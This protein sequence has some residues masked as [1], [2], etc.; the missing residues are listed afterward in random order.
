MA[1]G[2]CRPGAGRPKTGEVS[3]EDEVRKETRG[4]NLTPL[5]YMLSVMNDDEAEPV[6]RDRMAMAA[7]P[8]VHGRATDIEPGKKEQR[9]AKAEKSASAG[10]FASPVAPKL[11][12]NNR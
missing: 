3:V 2:G 4:T 6:R 9:Q 5:E 8:Y 12:V 7:A 1:R 10:R 11:V